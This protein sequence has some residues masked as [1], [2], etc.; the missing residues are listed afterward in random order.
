MI[1][2]R[3]VVIGA[4]AGGIDALR[5]VVSG[6]P[7]TFPAAI[8]IVVHTSPASPGVLAEILNRSTPLPVLQACDR[9][10]LEA[11]HI[12]VA[13]PDRHLVIEPGR[14]RVTKGPGEHR[15]RPAIDPMFRSAAQVFG[16]N[17]IG[18]VLTGN[19]D[20][21]VAGLSTIKKLGGTAIVQDP[22]EALFSS[23]P[24][25]ALTHVHVDHVVPLAE[26]PSLLVELTS[27]VPAEAGP[28]P[29]PRHIEVE[30]NIAKEQN[31]RD[32]GLEQIGKP[33]P[34]ACPECHGV[35]LEIDDDGRIRFRCHTGHA[36]SLESLLVAINQGIEK[37]LSAA[38]RSIEEGSLLMKDIATQLKRRNRSDESGRMMDAS[39]RAKQ[40][41]EVVRQLILE[42]DMVSTAS[43]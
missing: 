40:Q 8:C 39:D 13:P 26:M 25:E 5:V 24:L 16:P 42:P 41:A 3:V 28:L 34:Y 29:V 22:S 23:M 38:M 21:G 12:Y 7:E 43:N 31:P 18:I 33:S 35:L 17:A 1:A 9:Q 19:L 27:D 10:R 4:S 32:A 2:R 36:Y 20:D 30:V 11:G 37:S 14:L 6:L 15:F